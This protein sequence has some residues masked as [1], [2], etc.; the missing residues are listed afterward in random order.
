MG[1][2]KFSKVIDEAKTVQ[3]IL[4]KVELLKGISKNRG[5]FL[6]FS[7]DGSWEFVDKEVKGSWKVSDLIDY[8]GWRYTP[9]I[10][11]RYAL[12]D[13]EKGAFDKTEV[14]VRK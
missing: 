2:K 11:A 5:K 9:T 12:I 1:L 7:K 3:K 10:S 14:S 8:H 4:Y 6:V 13:I